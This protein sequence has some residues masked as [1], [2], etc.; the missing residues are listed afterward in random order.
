MRTG[1]L[2]ALLL[3]CSVPAIGCGNSEP[4][5]ALGYSENAK[6]AYEDAMVEFNSHNWIDAQ[7]M[8][9][10]VKR[11]Y[12]YSKYAKL[13]ELRIADADFEQDKFGEATRGYREFIRAHRSDADD[14]AYARSRIAEAQYSLIGDSFILPTTDERDQAPILEAYRELKSFVHDY[15]EAKETK[16]VRDLLIDVTAR[17]LRHELYVAR[18][19]LR[20]DNYDAAVTRVQYALRNFAGGVG[21]AGGERVDPLLVTSGLEAEALIVLGE[22]LLKQ[23]KWQAARDAFD[24]ILKTFPESGYSTQARNYLSYMKERGV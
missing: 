17:L 22:T 23:H 13:A 12:T 4:K 1:T 8:L 2:L 11:K 6:K 5:T 18:F 20:K 16:H 3:A 21:A 10:E 14:V 9:R 7:L 24:S 19:Y 15:P